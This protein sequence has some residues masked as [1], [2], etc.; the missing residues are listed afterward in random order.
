MSKLNEAIGAKR[1]RGHIVIKMNMP[2]V[3]SQTKPVIQTKKNGMLWTGAILLKRNLI[4]DD[5]DIRSIH[6]SIGHVSD[7]GILNIPT[8]N[9]DTLATEWL[10]AK[11][12]EIF[13]CILEWNNTPV[14]VEIFDAMDD[15]WATVAGY[16]DDLE[17]GE[18]ESFPD[19]VSRYYEDNDKDTMMIKPITYK[20]LLP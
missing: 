13:M 17:I 6:P 16:I 1:E 2:E 19:F 20:E 4:D 7:G 11:E 15:L 5:V 8:E 12:E 9:M 14:Q 10:K 18:D 3:G